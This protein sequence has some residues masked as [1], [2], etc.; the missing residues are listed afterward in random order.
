MIQNFKMLLQRGRVLMSLSRECGTTLRYCAS[1]GDQG[2]LLLKQ[3]KP[4]DKLG[5]PQ[6]KS[7]HWLGKGVFPHVS[8]Q[9]FFLSAQN[10]GNV[11]T[12]KAVPS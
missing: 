2:R 10:V 7:C 3:I 12:A 9:G 11:I 4:T 5:M 6:S 8:Q 1:S